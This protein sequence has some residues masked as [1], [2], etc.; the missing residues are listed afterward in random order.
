MAGAIRRTRVRQVPL[1]EVKNDLLPE[2]DYRQATRSGQIGALLSYVRR[3][4]GSKH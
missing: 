1:S 3:N 4:P 2:A